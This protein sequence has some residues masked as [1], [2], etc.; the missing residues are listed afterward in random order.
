[1]S[2]DLRF[3]PTLTVKTHE[4]AFRKSSVPFFVDT[5][6]RCVTV[7]FSG[8]LV[9][10][11]IAMYAKCLL[12]DAGFNPTFSE[13]VDLT[14]VTDFKLQAN[15]FIKLADKIDPFWPEAK[16]AFV[17]RT[18]VQNHAARMHKILRSERK[19]EIFQSIEEA[20]RWIDE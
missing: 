10:D 7:K 17:A 9:A 11:E 3:A 18:P 19:I 13:I 5:G 16:R 20:Q 4:K 6:K 2:N 8:E 12:S 15:D 14:Q 1:M